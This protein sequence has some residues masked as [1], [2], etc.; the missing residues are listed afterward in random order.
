MRSLDVNGLA[1]T[2]VV[3]LFAVSTLL[4][5]SWIPDDAFIS[6]RYARNL[7][8]GAGLV[9]NAGDR[10]E[11]VS[12]PLWTAVLALLTKVGLDTV[13]SA[14]VLSLLCSLVSILLSFRLFDAVLT[15]GLL[16]AD[17]RRRFIGLKTTIAA[18]LAASLPMIFYATSGLETHAEVVFLLSGVIL[19]LEARS[20]QDRRLLVAAQFSL[21]CVALLRPEGIMFLLLG[22]VFAAVELLKRDRGARPGPSTWIGVTAP[23]MVVVA[24]LAVKTAYYGAILPNT[25]FAKPGV[26]LDYLTPLWRGTRY[27]VRFF[28][29]SGL[30]LILPFC[31]IA[32]ID[33]RRRYASLFLAAFTTAQMAFIVL[34]GGDVLRFHRFTL[35]FTPFLLALALVGFV[36]LDALGRVQSRR[37]SIGAAAICVVAMGALNVGRVVLAQKKYCQHDWMHAQ[38]HRRI[39]VFLRDALPPDAA[40]V[41]NEVG[42]VAFESGLTTYD[43][44]GL[45]DETV[46]RIMYESFQ[47]YGRAESRWSVPK[48]ADYLMSKDPDCVIVPSYREVDPDTHRPE[49]G[50]MH[51][52]WEGLYTHPDLARRYRCGLCVRIHDG[53]YLY[54]YLRNHLE[55]DGTGG[56]SRPGRF[57]VPT[58]PSSACMTAC[59]YTD[60][61]STAPTN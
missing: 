43:M 53:K 50:H 29:I 39:G 58:P 16:Q 15:A 32:F 11:G 52:I 42:A 5:L 13:N 33:R 40:I 51:P 22:F 44:L 2:T 36:H 4:F 49:P 34:V 55:P 7:A 45:T 57:A 54:F 38:A 26:S 41:T 21:L 24:A 28:L 8:E 37:L 19:H 20:R 31:A 56:S 10:V 18:G 60:T 27:L 48:I 25:Y 1:R 59:E 61:R 14:V 47:R 46:S 35:P 23:L 9:F 6:F 30:V 3:V 17:E 12:N